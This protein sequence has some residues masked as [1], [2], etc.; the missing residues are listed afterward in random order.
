MQRYR[1]S[2]LILV[3]A[4]ALA[5]AGGRP[6]ARAQSLHPA[7]PADTLPGQQVVACNYDKELAVT[8]TGVDWTPVVADG[9]A[10]AGSMWAV[11]LLEVTN[12]SL[13]SEALTSRPLELHDG[14]GM[15][16]LV[17]EDPPDIT[18]VAREYGVVPPWQPFEP[19]ITTPSVVTFLVPA[20]STGLTLVGRRDYCD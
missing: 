18:E 3:L 20:D 1:L 4:L 13:I 2:P 10:P 11:V 9:L 14:A 5:A 7:T 6:A 16:Y 19:G 8:V 12:R 17:Q 15:V